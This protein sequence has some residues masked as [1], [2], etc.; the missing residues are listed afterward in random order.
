MPI[1]GG[2]EW[3]Q[4]RPLAML[5]E[6]LFVALTQAAAGDP[7]QTAPAA[8]LAPVA[9][10]ETTEQ[11]PAPQQAVRCRRE[12]VLGSR[13]S[14]RTRCTTAHQDRQEQEDSRELH[15]RMMEP[16]MAPLIPTM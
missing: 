8:D 11:A 5:L 10:Q 12:N 13:V 3:P 4:G 15:D 6:I 16:V 14:R 1:S 2:A 7:A 9:A